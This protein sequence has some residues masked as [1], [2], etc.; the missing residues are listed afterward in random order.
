MTEW[1][2]LHKREVTWAV[3][4]LAIVVGGFWYYERSQSI[5]AQ[6]AET[7]TFRRGKWWQ[8]RTPPFR[9]W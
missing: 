3:V 6:R 9:R 1:F 5:K 7:A 4:G 2:M 8:G